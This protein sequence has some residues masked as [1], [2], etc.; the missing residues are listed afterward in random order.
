MGGDAHRHA[1]DPAGRLRGT[2]GVW[3]ADGSLFPTA[4]GVN[5]QLP[6]MALASIV[7]GRI[8]AAG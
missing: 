7:A 8:L 5:P 2:D 1:C 3:V 4:P 6:I